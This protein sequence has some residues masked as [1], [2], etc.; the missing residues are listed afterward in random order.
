VQKSYSLLPE[1]IELNKDNYESELNQADFKSAT[2]ATRQT[3][4]LWVEQRTENKI[5]G[6]LQPG[7]LNSDT[8]HHNTVAL[9]LKQRGHRI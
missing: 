3:I 4:N 5:R 1:F 7:S 9:H 8:R 2:E 6:L